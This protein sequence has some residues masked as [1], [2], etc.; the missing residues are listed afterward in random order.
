MSYNPQGHKEL[1]VTEESQHAGKANKQ[2]NKKTY[3]QNGVYFMKEDLEESEKG[4]REKQDS[5]WRGNN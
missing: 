3:V 4:T 2:T 1:G 5:G